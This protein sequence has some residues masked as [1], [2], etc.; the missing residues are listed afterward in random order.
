MQFFKQDHINIYL[1]KFKSPK[2]ERQ[3]HSSLEPKRK[4]PIYLVVLAEIIWA[5]MRLMLGIDQQNELQTLIACSAFM[6]IFRFIPSRFQQYLLIMGQIYSTFNVQTYLQDYNKVNSTNLSTFQINFQNGMMQVIYYTLESQNFPLEVVS[7]CVNFGIII[8]Y[9][10]MP[11]E[12]LEVYIMSFI[13]IITYKHYHNMNSRRLFLTLKNFQQLEKINDVVQSNILIIQQ[14]N[15]RTYE[16]HLIDCNEKAKKLNIQK[17]QEAYTSYLQSLKIVENA[18]LSQTLLV[19]KGHNTKLESLKDVLLIRHSQVY[20]EM[21]QKKQEQMIQQKQKNKKQQKQLDDS[22]QLQILKG[23]LKVNWIDPTTKKTIK[24]NVKL[25]PIFINEP[26]IVIFLEDIT[27]YSQFMNLRTLKNNESQLFQ[28]FASFLDDKLTQIMQMG[29]IS[30][31]EIQRQLISIKQVLKFLKKFELT[32]S[33][34]EEFSIQ[35]VIKQIQILY[36]DFTH[37]QYVNNLKSEIIKS[38]KSALFSII[39][40]IVSSFKPTEIKQIIIKP[41]ETKFSSAIKLEV[42]INNQKNNNTQYRDFLNQ[43]NLLQYPSL[44]EAYTSYF[45]KL[46]K[47]IC[48][49][50]YYTC[51]IDE[52]NQTAVFSVEIIQDLSLVITTHCI[53]ISQSLI[54]LQPSPIESHYCSPDQTLESEQFSKVSITSIQQ[55]YS[56]AAPQNF[57]LKTEQ[58]I[59]LS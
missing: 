18:Q 28:S 56:S 22:D 36:E 25:V 53:Q 9:M 2:L 17:N 1:A 14:F 37:I 11:I 8:Y 26:L 3:F 30:V 48:L 31:K 57:K 50:S 51:E 59:Q 23:D 52:E 29:Q 15:S 38:N 54:K 16:M 27:I 39:L 5:S 13:I 20:N 7:M 21:M 33:F 12:Y 49:N 40:G 4:I 42:V 19:N 46:L 47:K 41:S 45:N 6:V 43:Y 58:Q 35:Q 32:Q 10:T 44:Y 24:Y 55:V 34:L